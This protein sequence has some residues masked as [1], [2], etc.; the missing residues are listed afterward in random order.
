MKNSD[1]IIK[2]Y[3]ILTGFIVL[4]ILCTF[5]DLSSQSTVITNSKNFTIDHINLSKQQQIYEKNLIKLGFSKITISSMTDDEV[6]RYGKINGRVVDQINIYRKISGS[7]E[8]Y[9]SKK[10]YQNYLKK[11]AKFNFSTSQL[12]R[13]NLKL[14]DEGNHKFLY[15]TEHHFDYSPTNLAPMQIELQ[16]GYRYTLLNTVGKQLYWTTSSFHSSNVKKG[17]VSYV[18]ENTPSSNITEE[19]MDFFESE[20]D[21]DFLSTKYNMNWKKPNLLQDIVGY[22]FYSISEFEVPKDQLVI[23]VYIQGSNP[24][25]SEQLYFDVNDK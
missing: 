21:P 15:I 25:L 3:T 17:K 6:Q 23:S 5:I 12:E 2:I 10:E 16:Y 7:N 22:H 8:K 24:H 13:I 9:I 20:S 4:Y 11:Y 1:N 18:S 19:E 14:I